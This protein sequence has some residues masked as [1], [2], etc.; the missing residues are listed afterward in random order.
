M[1]IIVCIYTKY[2]IHFMINM[3]IYVIVGI[4]HIDIMIRYKNSTSTICFKGEVI[5]IALIPRNK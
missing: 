2:H 4:L 1:Y 5:H 3:T